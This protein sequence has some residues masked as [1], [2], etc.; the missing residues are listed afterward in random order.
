MNDHQNKKLL[1]VSTNATYNAKAAF[2]DDFEKVKV[3]EWDSTMMVIALAW[4]VA[5]WV[6]WP[7]STTFRPRV[8]WQQCLIYAIVTATSQHLTISPRTT[9][10]LQLHLSRQ[11]C[12]S[13]RRPFHHGISVK[14]KIKTST[15][16]AQ[17]LNLN[18]I[19][20]VWQKLKWQRQNKA[21][22]IASADNLTSMIRHIR[23]NSQANYIQNLHRS[24]LQ[25]VKTVLRSSGI[26]I[27]PAHA[28]VAAMLFFG[29]MLHAKCQKINWLI[30]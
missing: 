5:V 28:L 26:I 1:A 17:A 6:V 8:S 23:Q 21:E 10:P 25:R 9:V 20:N 29:T 3:S 11:Q 7:T 18:I 27:R 13:P 30:G 2:A 22:C 14:N 19:E 16:M 15:W 4:E 24:I 12:Y